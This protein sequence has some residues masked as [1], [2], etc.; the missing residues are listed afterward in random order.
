[1]HTVY[2]SA[3]CRTLSP[4]YLLMFPNEACMWVWSQC[5]FHDAHA[6]TGNHRRNQKLSRDPLQDLWDAFQRGE[7]EQ[8]GKKN[9]RC[10][11]AVSPR[12]KNL[13]GLTSPNQWV[14]LSGS[15]GSYVAMIIDTPCGWGYSSCRW[16]VSPLR[17]RI[18]FSLWLLLDPEF[19]TEKSKEFCRKKICLGTNLRGIVT[20]KAS[21]L[22]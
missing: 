4:D 6:G 2:T 16:A 7:Q 17:A 9:Q 8:S 18:F 11:S 19:Y 10:R 15:L 1:M 22:T 3:Q 21:K 14:M 12:S 5:N 20:Y 13:E